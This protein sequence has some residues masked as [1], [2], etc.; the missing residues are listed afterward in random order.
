MV[1]SKIVDRTSSDV[2]THEVDISPK[3]AAR[4]VQSEPKI[5]GPVSQDAVKA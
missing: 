3:Y 2:F 5:V 4:S 1:Q